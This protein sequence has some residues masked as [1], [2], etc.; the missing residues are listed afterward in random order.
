[1]CKNM[2]ERRDAT[3]WIFMHFYFAISRAEDRIAGEGKE[4]NNEKNDN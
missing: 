1:M 2:E 3:S 4:H